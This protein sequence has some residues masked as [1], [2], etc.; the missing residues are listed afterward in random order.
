MTRRVTDTEFETAWKICSGS[1]RAVAT[2]LQLS[3][4]NVYN[5]RRSLSVQGKSDLQTIPSFAGSKGYNGKEDHNWQVES[6]PYRQR[7]DYTVRGGY[8]FFFG[9]CHW[10]P[11]EPSLANKALLILL[12]KLKPIFVAANGDVFDGA[13]ISR[14]EPLGW[15]TL[16]TVSEELG[17]VKQRLGE[18]RRAAPNAQLYLSPGNHCTRFDRR[19]ATE[20]AEFKDVVGF[21][22]EDHLKDW[23]M[24]YVAVLNKDTQI[25]VLVM[26]NFR[27]G[28]HAPWNNAVNAGST[29]ITG[30]LHSQNRTAHTTYFKTCY[31]VDH[32]LLAD[33]D[34]AA[35]SYTMGRPKNW[36]SGFCVM[37]FDKDGRHLPPELCEI[38]AYD[39]YKR[40]IWRGEVL[41]EE[42]S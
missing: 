35:F 34:H 37:K 4:R 19:L 1:P 17:I 8:A 12:K 5:R 2:Y 11:G 21:K 7:V 39:G 9:D 24:A 27:G 33:P 26:H 31:G 3:E 42:K 18:I 36:R 40:A 22:I 6:T 25:P 23:P 38:Q 32:G 20:T 29:I 14:H 13:S 15:V 28:V 30:H 10:W 41:C 16:P